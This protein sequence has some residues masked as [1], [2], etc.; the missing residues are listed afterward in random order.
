MP[1]F[2]AEWPPALATLRWA[3]DF[4]RRHVLVVVGL[5]LVPSVQRLVVVNWE[6]AIPGGV[7]TASEVVVMAV[8]VLLV[9]LVWRLATPRGA[10][11]WSNVD[12]FF[13]AHWPRLVI[14]GLLLAVATLVFN[15]GLEALGGVLSESAA[16]TYL[17]VLL[18]VKNPTIIAF[19]IVWMV[20]LVR[21]LLLPRPA[22]RAAVAAGER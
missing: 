16:R 17:A 22:D 8:R 18:F 9:V 1:R 12:P 5:S 11:S 6:G 20:G 15:N 13:A 19:T 2:R 10:A 21:D 7:A 4:Y 3:W 14:H